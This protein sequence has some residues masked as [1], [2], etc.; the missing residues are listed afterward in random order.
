MKTVPFKMPSKP[1]DPADA[2]VQTRD[3]DREE[4]PIPV[5]AT[6]AEPMKRFTIDVPV[7][8]HT[9]IKA[10]CALNGVKMADVL[11]ELL[12]REF[13]ASGSVKS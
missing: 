2:W 3:A 5:P 12:E 13:P 8:L 9:R 10:Q 6:P 11:R 1:A 4:K 7:S